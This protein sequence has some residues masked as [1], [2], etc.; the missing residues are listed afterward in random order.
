M[1]DFHSIVI[2]RD[3]AIA[4]VPG[5]SHSKA[6]AKAGWTENTHDPKL[7]SPRF[8]EWEW[9]GEGDIPPVR[10]LLKN[11]DIDTVPERVVQVAQRHAE[12]LKRVLTTGVIESPFDQDEYSDVRGLV[13]QN[14]A[15]PTE[16]LAALSTDSS[17]DVRSGVA[18]N[19]ATPTESLA[20]LAKDSSADVRS[21]VA[22]N[23]ATP[24]DVRDIALGKVTTK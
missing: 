5:N 2:R 22:R 11:V 24:V 7:V 10:Q 3:G 19:T 20:A 16:S 13:A 4:H 23:T 8:Y 15:T 1:C 21:W 17:T 6:V 18:Q 12:A 14:T 9:D